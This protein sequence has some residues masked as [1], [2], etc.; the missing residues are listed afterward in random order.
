MFIISEQILVE[1]YAP[2]QVGG[3]LILGQ[4]GKVDR[5]SASDYSCGVPICTMLNW[6]GQLLNG[7]TT[8]FRA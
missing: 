1:N 8:L 4:R 6:I 3:S 2:Y 5:N 7:L